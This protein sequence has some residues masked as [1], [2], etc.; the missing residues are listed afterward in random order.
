MQNKQGTTKYEKRNPN[1]TGKIPE[2]ISN[3]CTQCNQCVFVCPHAAIRPFVITKDDITSAPI[4]D[5]LVALKPMGLEFAGKQY[6]LAIS[7][8]DCT[9]CSACVKVCPDNALD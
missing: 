3:N 5:K 4:P 9:G 8:L 1:P 6:A 2:W 7:P